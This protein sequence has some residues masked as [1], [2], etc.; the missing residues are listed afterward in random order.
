MLSVFSDQFL[1]SGVK[2]I[3]LLLELLLGLNNPKIL[4]LLLGNP[5]LHLLQVLLGIKYVFLLR[6]YG[7]L[8]LVK[9][10]L[11]GPLLILHFVDHFLVLFDDVVLLIE[12]RLEFLVLLLLKV[13]FVLFLLEPCLLVFELLVLV[14]YFAVDL[15]ELD[16][17]LLELL[18][19]I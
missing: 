1:S 19:S 5:V 7:F 9:H 2:G 13:D 8:P 3:D 10:V 6:Q 12:Y 11:E 17:F 15:L 4:P 14:L 18:N 16:Y